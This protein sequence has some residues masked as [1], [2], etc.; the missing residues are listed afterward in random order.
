MNIVSLLAKSID[1]YISIIANYYI[2]YYIYYTKV[3]QCFYFYKVTLL[4]WTTSSIEISCIQFDIKR[5]KCNISKWICS[6]LLC[7]N[8]IFLFH[9]IMSR[10]R[11]NGINSM[12]QL[13]LLLLS[14]NVKVYLLVHFSVVK[15]I[16]NREYRD[17]NQNTNNVK[18]N[19][20][21]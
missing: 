1:R 14:W 3:N 2:G 11:R 17:T 9:N 19:D 10:R 12:S 8:I 6:H 21:I 16:Y 7:Y 4:M 15:G 18:Y 5:W 20:I 13:F